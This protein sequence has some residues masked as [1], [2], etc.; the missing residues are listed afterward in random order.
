MT[1]LKNILTPERT[2]IALRWSLAIIY[3]WFGALKVLGYDPVYEIINGTYPWLA[4]DIGMAILG[5]FEVLIGLGLLFNVWPQ[6]VGTILV[7]HMAGTFL[8]FL[9]NPALMFDPYFPIL[10]LSGE[11][12]VKNLTLTMAGLV[13]LAN[14]WKK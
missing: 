3:I 1:I 14:Q 7:V 12:V 2:I 10:S 6:A 11:F 9:T 13:I 4:T 8:T 5:W